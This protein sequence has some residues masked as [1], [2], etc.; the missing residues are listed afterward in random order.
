MQPWQQPYH[1]QYYQQPTQQNYYNQYQYQPYQQYQQ[2]YYN[3]SRL[4]VSCTTSG[5]GAYY[6]NGTNYYGSG[7]G[8]GSGQGYGYGGANSSVTWTAYASSGTGPYHYFWSGTDSPQSVDSSS[9]AV[10]YQV[11]GTK[12]MSVSVTS[13]D[14]QTATAS[15]GSAFAS[16]P[17]GYYP[18]YY[19]Y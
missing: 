8:N 6:G 2:P 17:S 4:N 5:A 16:A 7:Y 15:C 18:P 1:Q 14:G 10:G 11:A 13:S 12:Y 3:Y 19:Q 9:I